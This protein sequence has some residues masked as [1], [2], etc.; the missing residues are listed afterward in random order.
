MKLEYWDDRGEFALCL[1]VDE[2]NNLVNRLT[3]AE[4]LFRHHANN[5]MT[6]GDTV[7]WTMKAEDCRRAIDALGNIPHC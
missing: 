7:L 6:T 4:R 3:D 2:I 5:T 1:S